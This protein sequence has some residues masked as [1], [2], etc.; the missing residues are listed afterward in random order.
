MKIINMKK[1]IYGIFCDNL[2]TKRYRIFTRYIIPTP[3]G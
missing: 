2:L 3:V 1:R